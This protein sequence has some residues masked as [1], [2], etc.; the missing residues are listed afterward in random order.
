[1]LLLP[2]AHVKSEATS[3]NSTQEKVIGTSHKFLY[4]KERKKI[5]TE[6]VHDFLEGKSSDFNKM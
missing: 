2:H 3:H 1:M 4:S 5:L 6:T